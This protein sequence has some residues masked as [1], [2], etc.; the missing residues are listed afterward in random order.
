MDS[1][2]ELKTLTFRKCNWKNM[3]SVKNKD[4]NRAISKALLKQKNKTVY[5]FSEFKNIFNHDLYYTKFF[6]I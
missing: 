6:E 5:K 4:T 1:S 2:S 3:F